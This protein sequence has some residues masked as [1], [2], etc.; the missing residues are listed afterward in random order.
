MNGRPAGEP[1]PADRKD[2]SRTGDARVKG[3]TFFQAV[4]V[5]FGVIGGYFTYGVSRIFGRFFR[6]LRTGW[7]PVVLWFVASIVITL[8][9][10]QIIGHTGTQVAGTQSVAETQL[11]GVNLTDVNLAGVG[12]T[13]A[14][15][16]GVEVTG[17]DVSGLNLT[18]VDLTAANLSGANLAAS[19]L[20][21]AG[22]TG[23][24]GLASAESSPA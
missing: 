10:M 13:G 4:W 19:N 8:L 5:Y 3:I 23:L 17:T 2:G 22:L 15:L 16:T 9:V 11:T 24:A 7:R 20:T 1:A 6:F 18:G 14:N 21:A 12:I